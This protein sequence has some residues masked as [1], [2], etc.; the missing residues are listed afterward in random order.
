[1]LINCKGKNF[2]DF[3]LW[4]PSKTIHKREEEEVRP[5]PFPPFHP[6][7]CEKLSTFLH[8]IIFLFLFKIKNRMNIISC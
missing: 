4:N 8:Y 6:E 1:M 5:S 7:P 3:L 2:I